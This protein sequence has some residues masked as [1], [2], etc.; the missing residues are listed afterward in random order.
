[1]KKFLMIAAMA[2]ASLTATAQTVDTS[3]LTQQQIQELA[4][5]AAEMKQ[6]TNI[7]AAVRQE[8]EAWGELGANMGKAVVGAAREVGVAANEFA[9]TPLGKVVV[10]LTIYKIAGNDLLGVVF[11]SITLLVGTILAIWVAKTK[12]FYT[13]ECESKQV[14]WGMFNRNIITKVTVDDK[15]AFAK[16]FGAAVLLILTWLI[17]LNTIF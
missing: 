14:L 5:K 13:R 8:A 10:F 15:V 1:M 7:S 2:F 16:M 17:G 6:P 12:A 9:Q 4:A 3:G 11:G